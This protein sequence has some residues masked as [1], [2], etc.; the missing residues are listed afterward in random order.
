MSQ[1]PRKL[2]TPATVIASIALLV[3]LGGTSIAAVSALP[4]A[5]VGTA[6]LKPGAVTSGKIKDRAVTTADIAN[7]GV[8]SVDVRNGSLRRVDF[9]PG[10]LPAGPVGPQGP[11][12]PAGVSGREDILA[13]TTTTSASP[14][15]ARATC[16]VGKKVIG[17]GVEIGGNGRNRVTVTE[18]L[19]AGDNA[20][21]AEA[22]E[23]VSTKAT[24]KLEVHAICA[25]VS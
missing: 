7:G 17:G 10:Q 6:Q 12:G 13:E 20:W 18:S 19:P 15:A 22:F 23:A 5:S 11:P 4:R 16:T 21:E 14:K 3:A 24:W 8:L 2:P 9:R 25:N 1:R